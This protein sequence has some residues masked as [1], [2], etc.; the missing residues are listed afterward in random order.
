MRCL[1]LLFVFL[2]GGKAQAQQTVL[3]ECDGKFFPLNNGMPD[4]SVWALKGP[5]TA[6]KDDVALIDTSKYKIVWNAC[7][8][9]MIDD[10]LPEQNFTDYIL[11]TALFNAKQ[12]LVRITAGKFTGEL[13]ELTDL[14]GNKL[15]VAQHLY[16]DNLLLIEIQPLPAGKY[17]CLLRQQNHIVKQFEINIAKL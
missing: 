6:P 17:T 11:Y 13:V 16:K 7:T 8:P 4:Y 5:I 9:G 1:L 14:N 10:V 2:I 3:L 12:K 15:A